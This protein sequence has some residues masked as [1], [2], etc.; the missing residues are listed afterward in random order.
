M[1][2]VRMRL[3]RQAVRAAQYAHL[4]LA[5]AAVADCSFVC[6]LTGAPVIALPTPLQR[7]AQPATLHLEGDP[8]VQ[9]V[10]VVSPCACEV[11]AERFGRVLPDAEYQALAML[12]IES[13]RLRDADGTLEFPGHDWSLAA[14]EW[15][16]REDY[17]VDHM[18]DDHVAEMRA[19]VSHFL[20]IED[21]A[22]KMLCADPEGVHLATSEGV[23]YL[24]FRHYCN[25]V[26][27]V[28]LETVYLAH[29]AMG[30]PTA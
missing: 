4:T 2:A 18:N 6:A 25:T 21:P 10:G 11:A 17:I 16:A 5:R 30:K 3:A 15:F 29:T 26:K 20:G 28:A 9:L 23:R 24:P 27:E 13:G 22:P 19:M 14:A 12:S 7:D 1:T 8:D